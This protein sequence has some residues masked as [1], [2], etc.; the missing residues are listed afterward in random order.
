[1][2]SASSSWFE[3][4]LVFTNP[5]FNSDHNYYLSHNHQLVCWCQYIMWPAAPNMLWCQGVKQKLFPLPLPLN[6]HSPPNRAFHWLSPWPRYVK[7]PAYQT[8]PLP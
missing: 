2:V 8:P 3:R 1:L 7:P 4:S 6:P 5:G